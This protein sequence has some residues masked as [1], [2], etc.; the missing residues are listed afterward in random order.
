MHRCHALYQLLCRHCNPSALSAPP[1]D[2]LLPSAG[3][4][5]AGGKPRLPS[6]RG[7]RPRERGQPGETISGREAGRATTDVASGEGRFLA[8]AG[9][10]GE[11]VDVGGCLRGRIWCAGR[12]GLKTCFYGLGKGKCTF[13]E[14][15]SRETTADNKICSDAECRNS[16]SCCDAERSRS[17]SSIYSVTWHPPNHNEMRQICGV[18]Y[19]PPCPSLIRS[20]KPGVSLLNVPN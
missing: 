20:C 3:R 9:L 1:R 8:E 5:R 12:E 10:V 14:G 6:L 7:R 17:C 18:K 4:N 11:S 2:G 16:Y 15:E 19:S 13:V